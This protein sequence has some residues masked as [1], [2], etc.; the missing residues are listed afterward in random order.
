M[1][2]IYVPILLILSFVIGYQANLLHGKKAKKETTIEMSEADK[3]KQ[4][5]IRDSFE[6]LMN[7]DYDTA[8]KRGDE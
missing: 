7:Y 5:K 2:Y 4:K 8:L 3:E 1:E 6:E